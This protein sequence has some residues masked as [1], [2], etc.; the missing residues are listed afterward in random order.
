[1]FK[2]NRVL[3]DA[4]IKRVGYRPIKQKL[5]VLAHLYPI[6]IHA[7]QRNISDKD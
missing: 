1:M 5:D 7:Q 6:D 3:H 4:R 2:Y